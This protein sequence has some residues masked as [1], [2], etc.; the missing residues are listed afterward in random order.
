MGIKGNSK[1]GAGWIP[2]VNNFSDLFTRLRVVYL[3]P[4]VGTMAR[5]GRWPSNRLRDW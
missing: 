1:F 3:M 5:E 4:Q 2:L